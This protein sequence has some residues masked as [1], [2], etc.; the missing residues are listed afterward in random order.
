MDGNARNRAGL[1]PSQPRRR[2]RAAEMSPR[3][4][5]PCQA[6]LDPPDAEQQ[7]PSRSK[8]SSSLRTS[9]S[10]TLR[11]NPGNAPFLAP[12]ARSRRCDAPTTFCWAPQKARDDVFVQDGIR[13]PPV[14]GFL[15][16]RMAMMDRGPRRP[17]VLR[18]PAE[19]EAPSSYAGGTMVP[20]NRRKPYLDLRLVVEPPGVEGAERG[21][22]RC[23][24]ARHE[25]SGR[26]RTLGRPQRPAQVDRSGPTSLG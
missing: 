9:S 10:G 21:D 3:R 7:A 17:S 19:A 6:G 18:P 1:G 22:D 23:K 2:D 13:H 8:C 24:S 15:A 12:W 11:G 5:H 14:E 4:G 25:E 26:A 16:V 20:G